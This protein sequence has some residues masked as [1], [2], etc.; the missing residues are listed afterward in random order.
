[1]NQSAAAQ[2][3]IRVLSWAGG[4]G[5]A[6]AE[7]VSRPFTEATGINVEH[8]LHVGIELPEALVAALDGGAPPPVDV[9]WCNTIPALL[10]ANS[11][12]CTP[13]D[14][15]PILNELRERALPSSVSGWPFVQA[16]VVH[17]VLVYQRSLYPAA[18]PRSWSA[19]TRPEHQGRVVVY[20]GGKGIFPVAQI[21]GGGRLED[22]PAS[23]DPCWSFLRALRPQLAPPRYSIGLEA[24]IRRGEIDLCYRALTNALAFEAEGLAIG[25]TAPEEGVADT[26]DALWI[27]RGLDEAT[28][29]RA[30]RYLSFALSRPIQE[31][32]CQLLGALPVHAAAPSPDLF[33]SV[34]RLPR[35][36]DDRRGVLHVPAHVEAAHEPTWRAMFEKLCAPGSHGAP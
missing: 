34:A 22:I 17:Y 4:W 6:L 8:L 16:Y 25:W 11:Q 30:R 2:P 15:L 3:S 10:A 24:P 12:Y 31:R 14:D 13:L 33:R 1:M 27:P 5:R 19:L 32:W 28:T 18:A 29:D 9:V 7:A 20:P 21:V 23:M 36:A 35:D 26:T